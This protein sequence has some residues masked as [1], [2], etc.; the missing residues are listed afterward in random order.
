MRNPYNTHVTEYVQSDTKMLPSTKAKPTKLERL[1]NDDAEDG[2]SMIQT[3]LDSDSI[4]LP[5]RKKVRFCRRIESDSENAETTADATAAEQATNEHIELSGPLSNDPFKFSC[6]CGAQ[7]D[8]NVLSNG[9][10]CVQCEQ[11]A[12]YNQK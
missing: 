7:G 1:F 11:Y 9:E 3:V 12:C 5:K 8:G 4:I 2:V 6:R 10:D